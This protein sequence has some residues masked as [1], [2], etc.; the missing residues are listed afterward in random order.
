M[1]DSPDAQPLAQADGFTPAPFPGL[2]EPAAAPASVIPCQMH[3]APRG[4]C[5][6]AAKLSYRWPGTP[7]RSSVCYEHADQV[8]KVAAAIALPDGTLDWGTEA[9]LAAM[10]S[11]GSDGMQDG[12]VG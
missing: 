9:A 2:H 10:P 5:P 11:T 1:L 7:E 8:A 6:E 4:T 3:D 12:R